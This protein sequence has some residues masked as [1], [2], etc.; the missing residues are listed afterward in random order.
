MF[1]LIR[2]SRPS[3]HACTCVC[4][5]V[6]G[7]DE[8]RSASSRQRPVYYVAN[9]QDAMGANE[10]LLI[11][12]ARWTQRK[13]FNFT[14]VNRR[15]WFVVQVFN[16]FGWA[17]THTHVRLILFDG[18]LIYFSW[19]FPPPHQ[20]EPSACGGT[21]LPQVPEEQRRPYVDVSLK[22]GDTTRNKSS[23]SLE[24]QNSL[25]TGATAKWG[26]GPTML[27]QLH[28]LL[29]GM[30]EICARDIPAAP[31]GLLDCAI[32]F[33]MRKIVIC[34]KLPFRYNKRQKIIDSK[35]GNFV[36]FFTWNP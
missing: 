23:H 36:I 34:Y 8:H 14:R 9:E 35:Q 30:G 33:T 22:P 31:W 19:S 2:K 26:F 6:Y 13:I 29:L 7:S 17:H 27:A 3:E 12:C 1:N 24:P 28:R 20:S 25:L 16:P 21:N 32:L 5:C 4:V 18:K 15:C 11:T 10:Q